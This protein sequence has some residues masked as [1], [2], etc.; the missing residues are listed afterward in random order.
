MNPQDP[1]PLQNRG[2]ALAPRSDLPT[3]DERLWAVGAHLAAVAGW[4]GIPMGHIV[5]PLVVWA[6]KRDSSEFVRRQSIESLNF[7]ISMTLYAFLAGLLAI[8]VI[9]L[10]V[11]IPM[12]LVLIVSD[13]VLTLVGAYRASQG[14]AYRY[15]CTIRLL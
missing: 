4:V 9:G 10:V 13:I 1:P 6:I 11:A 5:A 8:T 7:Q 3:S 15:P 14:E 12:I 2:N